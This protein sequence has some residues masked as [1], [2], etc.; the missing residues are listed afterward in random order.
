MINQPSATNVERPTLAFYAT[1]QR[2]YDHFN[3]T[4]FDGKLSDCLMTLRSANRVYGYHHAKRF[5]SPSG[6]KIDELGLHPGFFTLR[7][8]EAVL[9]TLV[10]EMVHH[11]QEHLGSPSPSN[12]HN[13]QWA[14]K[15]E[16]LGLQPS[17]T[18]LPGG[19]RTGRTVSHFILPDGKF[20]VSCKALLETG[21]SFPWLDR[22]APTTPENVAA[23]QKAL[24]AAGI[25]TEL[26]Q[27][28]VLT[29]PEEKDG[30]SP[31][32]RPNPTRVSNR[33]KL[34]C[35]DCGAK[36]WVNRETAIDCGRCRVSMS[37]PEE[38]SDSHN[39]YAGENATVDAINSYRSEQN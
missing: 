2:A 3:A 23:V 12:P 33:V 11:W 26:T 17:H 32:F 8:A 37:P 19:R 5:V 4:L 31:V 39:D 25:S 15:M 9:S 24:E 10:H 29:L 21:F 22:H 38:K 1:L 30:S 27:P 36:A 14:E 34:V 20:F 28:P 7:P 13:Q 16:S 6:D 35:P 18:G